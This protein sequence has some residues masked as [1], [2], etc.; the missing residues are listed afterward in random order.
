MRRLARS[1]SPGAERR[2][3][4]AAIGRTGDWLSQGDCS[5]REKAAASGANPA[6]AGICGNGQGVGKVIGHA[7]GGM[8]TGGQGAIPVGSA[9]IAAAPAGGRQPHTE[10]GPYA[11]AG[12]T[13]P[14]YG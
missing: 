8:V 9:A 2:M 1:S 3:R 4:R 13:V 12:V 11:Q 14:Q 10:L 5:P 7:P 6:A